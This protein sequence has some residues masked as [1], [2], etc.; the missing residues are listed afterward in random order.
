VNSDAI[1]F[2]YKDFP[3]SDPRAL[4]KDFPWSDPR[5]VRYRDQFGPGR[6]FLQI[7]FSIAVSDAWK[8]EFNPSLVKGNSRCEGK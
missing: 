4:D 8:S 1:V 7:G 5:V 2:T 6:N 3:W